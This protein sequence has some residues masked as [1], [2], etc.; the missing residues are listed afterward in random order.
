MYALDRLGYRGSYDV[1]DHQ[2]LGTTNNQLGGRATIQQAQGYNLIVYDMGNLNPSG[3]QLPDGSSPDVQKVDQAGWFSAWLAQASLSEAQHA[4]LWVIGSNVLEEKSGIPG[5]GGTLLNTH[6][7]VSLQSTD[8]GLNVNPDVVGMASFTFDKGSGAA[9]VDFAGDGY[10]VNGGCPIIRNYDAAEAGAAT[11]V[12][13]HRYRSPTTN[14]LGDAAIVMNRNDAEA[15]NTIMQTHPWFD[16]RDAGG[17]PV[18]TPPE[19][20]LLSK[21]LGAALPANCLRAPT[22]TDV[23]TEPELAV[24]VQTVLRQN[25]PNPFNPMTAILFDLAQDGPVTLKIYDVSGRLVRTL[26]DEAMTAGRNHR[27][28]WDG[29]DDQRNRVASGVYFYRLETAD[30]SLTKKLVVMK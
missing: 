23:G 9:T 30:T 11:S 25:V 26:V 2:G 17:T 14:Q 28:V 21:I 3:W 4:T 6:M 29:L 24:P 22:P 8:Q 7:G 15:Y 16:I 20:D 18:A 27:I 1:Y 12:A 10:T 5:S 19:L 13:T